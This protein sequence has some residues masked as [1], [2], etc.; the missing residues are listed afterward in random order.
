MLKHTKI[1]HSYHHKPWPEFHFLVCNRN[2][3][4]D[5]RSGW[6]SMDRLKAVTHLIVTKEMYL[7]WHFK[8]VAGC[9]SYLKV[10][11]FPLGFKLLLINLK[12]FKHISVYFIQNQSDRTIDFTLPTTLPSAAS[13]SR[14]SWIRHEVLF[15]LN[16][17]FACLPSWDWRPKWQFSLDCSHYSL[18][19]CFSC[20]FYVTRT[21][22]PK[23]NI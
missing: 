9:L 17:S 7:N 2:Y 4:F 6:Y 23:W 13:W 18:Q 21:W 12:W 11:F 3:S 15:L 16:I 14:M 8:Q 20:F 1:V 10:L 22:N 19:D 5:C